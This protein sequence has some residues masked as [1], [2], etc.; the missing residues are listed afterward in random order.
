MNA[1]HWFMLGLFT[2]WIPGMLVIAVLL[3][4]S[5]EGDRS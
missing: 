2:G 1:T 3:M 4:R 5:A